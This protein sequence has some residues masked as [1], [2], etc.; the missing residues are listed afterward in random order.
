[1]L[2]KG[3]K[4]FDVKWSHI[5]MNFRKWPT[6]AISMD[7]LAEIIENKFEPY[8]P[9]ILI[10]NL[11]P[12][13]TKAEL[14]EECSKYGTV[15]DVTIFLDPITKKSLGEAEVYYEAKSEGKLY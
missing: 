8:V 6:V 5:R 12:D 2:C 10:G 3:F 11:H 15:L 1:M 14:I 4:R 7:P 13:V 9:V